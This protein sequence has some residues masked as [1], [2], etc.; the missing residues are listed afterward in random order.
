MSIPVSLA[1]LPDTQSRFGAYAYLLTV[2][3][4]ATPRATSVRV[5]WQGAK[6]M[7]GAGRRSAANIAVNDQVAILWPPPTPGDY[8]LI[9]DGWA[10]VQGPVVLIQ[11]RSAILH[12]TQRPL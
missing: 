6:L 5:E 12:V 1:E 4:D 8:S 9:V 3:P 11:P 2:S 7:V 10:D